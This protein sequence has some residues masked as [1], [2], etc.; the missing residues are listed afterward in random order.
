MK[1]A[2]IIDLDGTLSDSSKRIHHVSGAK[3]NFEAFYAAAKYDEPN[4][5][6]RWIVD[7]LCDHVTII[8]MTGRPMRYRAETRQWIMEYTR[9]KDPHSYELLMREDEDHTKDSEMKEDL[10]RQYVAK[11]FNVL[12]AIDDRTRVVEMWRKLGIPCLQCAEGNF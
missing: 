5:W 2:I 3:K 11:Y 1:P 10:Y 7:K 12:F 4:N 8:F 9:L 6:C